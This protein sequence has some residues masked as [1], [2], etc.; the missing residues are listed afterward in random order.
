MNAWILVVSTA[1]N[2][3]SGG[4]WAPATS[5]AMQEFGSQLACAKAA[6]TVRAQVKAQTEELY[7]SSRAS[8]HALCV[9]K[10]AK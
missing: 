9:P 8:V 7:G 2:F 3:Y 4:I 10:D 6:D 1:W 5:V